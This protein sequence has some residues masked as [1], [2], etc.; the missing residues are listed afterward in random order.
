MPL[1][2]PDKAL[3]RLE[4]SFVPEQCDYVIINIQGGE[5]GGGGEEGK[6]RDVETKG[7]GQS[8]PLI[9]IAGLAEIV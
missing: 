4:V 6:G 9:L 8:F 7:S 5:V 3:L 2:W 1:T